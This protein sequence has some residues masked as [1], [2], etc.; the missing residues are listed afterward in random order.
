MQIR[1]GSL[2]A[3]AP[4]S[5]SKVQCFQGS[6]SAAPHRERM[7]ALLKAHPELR[8]LVGPAPATAACI[9]AVC[10]AQLGAALLLAQAPGW[11]ILLASYTVGAVLS[12]ALWTLLHETTHDLVF[13]TG[14]A[15]RLTGLLASLPLGLPVG[16][17]FRQ[18]HLLHHRHPGDPIL[19]ADVPSPWEARLVGASPCRKALWLFCIAGVQSLRVLR[20]RE[21]KLLDRWLALNLAS[22]AIFTVLLLATAGPGALGYLV[23]STLFSI[24]L[25]PL[26]GRWIQEHVLVRPDQETYSY[27]GPMNLLVFN[28]GYHHE[29]HDLMRVPWMR[30][31][32]VRRIAPKFYAELHAHRSWTALLIRFLTD[33]NLTLYSRAVRR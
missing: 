28:A 13:R 2:A 1:R 23:A 26:G 9:A 7:R 10:G 17:T 5:T 4:G 3:A 12:L 20:M 31:P 6:T 32:E 18:C 21:V 25:H 11:A 33:R 22:Q 30:L 29:H 19:D 24:G 15:N 14:T 27:Y 16:A 8:G